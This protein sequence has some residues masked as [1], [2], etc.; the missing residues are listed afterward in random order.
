MPFWFSSGSTSLRPISA[1]PTPIFKKNQDLIPADSESDNG[2][3]Q[4]LTALISIEDMG[5]VAVFLS[6][7][8]LMLGKN[9]F[10]GERG[11]NFEENDII[12]WCSINFS[13]HIDKISK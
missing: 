10:L 13:D 11:A 6:N 12:T 4:Q 3:N 7:F 2:H 9:K 1:P 5:T 8:P